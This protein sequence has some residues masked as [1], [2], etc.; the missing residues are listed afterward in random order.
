[1]DAIVTAVDDATDVATPLCASPLSP[2]LRNIEIRHAHHLHMLMHIFSAH[3]CTHLYA[4]ICAHCCTH[5]H[6]HVCAH[7]VCTC[8][9]HTCPYTCPYTRLCVCTYIKAPVCKYV[10]TSP[11]KMGRSLPHAIAHVYPCV[12]THFCAQ[13]P[14]QY[15]F[16]LQ[17]RRAP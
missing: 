10:Y 6:A 16:E 1:M 12:N 3:V 8:L 2:I 13:S 4:H 5:V 11:S 9:S 14:D 7:L 17:W 15:P